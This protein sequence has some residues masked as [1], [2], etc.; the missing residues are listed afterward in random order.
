MQGMMTFVRV[1]PP[2]EYE[3]VMAQIRQGQPMNMPG[4][5]H[6]QHPM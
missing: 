1:L 4:M 2:A 6:M 3:Q 5:K